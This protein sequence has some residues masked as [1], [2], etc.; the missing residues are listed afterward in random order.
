MEIAPTAGCVF[1]GEFKLFE[2]LAEAVV[3]WELD[4][5]QLSPATGPFYL[6][7]LAGPSVLISRAVIQA[8]FY[9]SGGAVPEYRTVSLVAPGYRHGIW[10]WCGQAV[11]YNSLLVMPEGG[12]FESVSLGAYDSLHLSLSTPLLQQVAQSEFG[13]T[14]HQLMP[15]GRCFCPDGGEALELL[16][17]LLLKITNAPRGNQASSS[18]DP[19]HLLEYEM[20]FLVLSCLHGDRTG[21]SV[22][23]NTKRAKALAAALAL[24]NAEPNQLSVKSLVAGTGVSRRTLE[25]AFRDGLDISPAAFLKN[26]RLQKLSRALLRADGSSSRVSNILSANGFDHQGQCAADYKALFNELPSVTLK[27]LA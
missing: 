23:S 17:S 22:D 5:C 10:R 12:D 19:D 7:Q 8:K 4:F 24:I 21:T 9:Q 15:E 26:L 16:R 20:A 18:L 14:L 6:Q 13:L 3:G 25:N 11:S 1:K 2:E 27:R